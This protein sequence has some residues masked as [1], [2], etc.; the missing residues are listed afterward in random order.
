MTYS[1][2]SLGASPQQWSL[3]ASTL[4]PFLSSHL[5]FASYSPEIGQTQVKVG[6]DNARDKMNQR[7]PRKNGLKNYVKDWR[8]VSVSRMIEAVRKDKVD[9]IEAN[10]E[11]SQ[12]L[13]FDIN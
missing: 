8:L 3:R 1:S 4:S 7:L 2:N 13:T 12:S 10:L 11:I 5:S 9:W 6:E